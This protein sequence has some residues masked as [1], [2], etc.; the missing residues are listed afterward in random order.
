[1]TYFDINTILDTFA[2]KKRKANLKAE[3][4]RARSE[5]AEITMKYD[6][7]SGDFIPQIKYSAKE[8][9]KS[10][11][12]KMSEIMDMY[13]DLEKKPSAIVSGPGGRPITG[14]ID[15]AM[16]DGE[17]Q[18]FQSPAGQMRERGFEPTITSSGKMYPKRI[19]DTKSSLSKPEQFTLYKVR[20]LKSQGAPIETINET[21]ESAKLVPTE[22]IFADELEGYTPDLKKYVLIKVK[23]LRAKGAPAAKIKKFIEL[24]G[25]NPN[26]PMFRGNNRF[27]PAASTAASW[28]KNLIPGM[29]GQPRPNNPIIPPNPNTGY[30]EL[31]YTPGE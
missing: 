21:I 1:M 17:R 26:D 30:N 13:G 15:E 9:V 16:V 6:I 29:G 28:M 18:I 25:L 8:R 19:S 20:Q 31:V 14:Q 12:Q 7:E 27:S 10:P 4:D 5:G 22:G 23:Q 3:I 2:K 11:Q 24:N